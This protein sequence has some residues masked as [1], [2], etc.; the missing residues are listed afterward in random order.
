MGDEIEMPAWTQVFFFFLRQKILKTIF[1]SK[2]LGSNQYFISVKK[3]W[4]KFISAI[5][6]SLGIF[7]S[8]VFP[9]MFL[10]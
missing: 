5:L 8:T 6:G 9:Y 3:K 1:Y 2:I 7:K 4:V 10:L